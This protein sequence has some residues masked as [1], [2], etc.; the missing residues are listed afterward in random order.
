MLVPRRHLTC[1]SFLTLDIF[2]QLVRTLYW[3][4]SWLFMLPRNEVFCPRQRE[5]YCKY[6]FCIIRPEILVN[7]IF[8]PYHSL[9]VNQLRH[10]FEATRPSAPTRPS[11]P[12]WEPWVS[13][14]AYIFSWADL[15]TYTFL[16]EFQTMYYCLLKWWIFLA[17]SSIYIY[18]EIVHFLDFFIVVCF[19][20]CLDF[21]WGRWE[22]C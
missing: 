12:P 19:D 11:R 13:P 21:C 10:P 2:G 8:P 22:K 9:Q 16:H 3:I 20:E 18:L 15:P 5:L 17:L 6:L 14:N 4:N 7:K 1:S